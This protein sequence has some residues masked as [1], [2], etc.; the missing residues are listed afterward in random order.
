MVT[1]EEAD[2]MTTIPQDPLAG[3]RRC[4]DGVRQG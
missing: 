1:A 3:K 4:V 2:I